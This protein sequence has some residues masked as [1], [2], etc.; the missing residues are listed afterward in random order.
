M[1]EQMKRKI[2]LKLYPIYKMFSWDLLFYFAIIFLFLTEVKGLT[3]SEVLLGDAFY[4]IFKIFFQVLCVIL[5]D[6]IGKRK[7]LLLGNIF[8]ATSVIILIIFH[9]LNAL[10]ISNF[11]AAFGF[12]LKGICEPIILND[13]IPETKYKQDIFARI[14]GTA[15][16]LHFWLAA[17]SAVTTG[18]LF[19]INGYLP[20]ILCFI[21]C[22]ISTLISYR[23][24]DV[25]TTTAASDKKS[26][27]IKHI[28]KYIKDLRRIFKYMLKS[29][30][31][32]SLMLSSAI[33]LPLA[34]LSSPTPHTSPSTKRIS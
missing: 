24:E 12:V 23:F 7:S 1:D 16:S 18:F 33:I 27:S 8:V 17:I 25:D 2:N 4:P 28:W 14:D 9:G 34:L 26:S 10:I 6:H 29:K 21:F 31:L 11:V 32:I 3:A 19:A 22:L 30:R 13:S 5:I 15:T 20:M